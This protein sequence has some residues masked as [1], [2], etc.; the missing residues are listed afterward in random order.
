M[1]NR[2]VIWLNFFIRQNPSRYLFTDRLLGRYLEAHEAEFF[3]RDLG[4][5][6]IWDVGAS[7]GKITT[8]MAAKSP[9]AT[10][11]A[12]EPNLNS[13]YFLAY[14]T[15]SYGNVVLVPCALTTDGGHITGTYDPDFNAP[16]TGPRVSTISIAEAIAKTGVPA[17]I[18]M[19][20]EGAEYGFFESSEAAALRTATILVAWHPDLTNKPVPQVA[21]WKNNPIALN[22]TLLTPL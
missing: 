13:L 8:I 15:A 3:G 22:S 16:P 21:G 6:A 20:I 12:F 7:V 4:K 17:F 10:I 5:V 18:K 14:R 1:I 19:D 9:N 2:F 11:Y